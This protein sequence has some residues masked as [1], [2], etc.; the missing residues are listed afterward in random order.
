MSV[1]CQP[2]LPDDVQVD[3]RRVFE[4]KLLPSEPALGNKARK[5]IQAKRDDKQTDE[6]VCIW[7]PQSSAILYRMS[8]ILYTKLYTYPK[9]RF[10]DGILL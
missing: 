2:G 10:E 3:T 5:S 4:N 9:K 8:L 6:V 7:T 1:Q